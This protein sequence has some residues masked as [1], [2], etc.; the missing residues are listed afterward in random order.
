MPDDDTQLVG[1]VDN[2]AV[3]V[4]VGKFCEKIAFSCPD[5]VHFDLPQLDLIDNGRRENRLVFCHLRMSV[6][7]KILDDLV[8]LDSIHEG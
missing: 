4:E 5:A 1:I 2:R 3:L 6:D 7:S 8:C